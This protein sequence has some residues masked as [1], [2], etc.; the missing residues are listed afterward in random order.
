MPRRALM[1][2]FRRSCSGAK[3][4]VALEK[5]CR[6]VCTRPVEI[7]TLVQAVINVDSIRHRR[8]PTHLRRYGEH[9]K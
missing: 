9:V 3:T 8:L 6:A 4:V 2:S 1:A 5:A 7:V